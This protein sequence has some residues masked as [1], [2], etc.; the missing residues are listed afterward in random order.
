MVGLSAFLLDATYAIATGTFIP[1]LANTAANPSIFPNG[2]GDGMYFQIIEGATMPTLNLVFVTIYGIIDGER[3]IVSYNY[4]QGNW[5]RIRKAY[6]YTVLI[7]FIY[8]L[9]FA[10]IIAIGINPYILRLFDVSQDMMKDAQLVFAIQ[11]L[12]IPIF[13]AQIAS[14]SIYMS[15]GD[16]FRS[17]ISAVFQDIITFF[18]VLGIMYGITMATQ[19]I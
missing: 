16:T 2:G 8:A 10:V 13:S 4:S 14:I 9:V 5:K 12:M 19:N 3:L 11:M 6:F 1:I 15:I 17:N 18:P 7:A